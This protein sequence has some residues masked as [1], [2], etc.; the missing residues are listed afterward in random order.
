MTFFIIISQ[1]NMDIREFIKKYDIEDPMVDQHDAETICKLN[2]IVSGDIDEHYDDP[3]FENYAGLYYVHEKKNHKYAEHY[4]LQAI[5]NGHIDAMHNLGGLYIQLKKYDLAEHY[6]LQA[7]KNGNINAIHNLGFMYFELKKY[8]QAEHYYMR[9]IGFGDN[10]SMFCLGYMY[11]ELKKYDQA[12]QYYL[13]AIEKGHINAMH[14]LGHMYRELKKY[15]QAERYYLMAVERGHINA[16]HNLG[17][18]FYELK[19]YDQAEHYFLMTLSKGSDDLEQTIRCLE[20]LISNLLKLFVVLDRL[21]SS[22]D[23]VVQKLK[24]LMNNQTVRYFANKRNRL[25][26]DG[27]CPVCY[28]ERRLIPRECAHCYCEDCYVRIERCCFGCDN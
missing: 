15:D 17:V 6:Y 5:K 20:R 28:D 11:K 26:K 23:I 14:N 19:K 8:D 2:R 24:E 22:N 16:M 9:S 12:E 3:M 25:S 1:R 7:I 18:L 21:K 13:M 4:Y 27:E 10:I